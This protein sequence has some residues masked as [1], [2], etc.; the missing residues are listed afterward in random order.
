[1][2]RITHSS[3]H[4]SQYGTSFIQ[5]FILS[6][7][8]APRHGPATQISTRK[9]PMGGILRREARHMPIEA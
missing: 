9:Y 3:F 5:I 6:V 1:M 7:W 8:A 4:Y 2:K